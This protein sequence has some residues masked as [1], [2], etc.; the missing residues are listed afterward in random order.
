M[1]QLRPSPAAAHTGSTRTLTAVRIRRAL[2]AYQVGIWV[3]AV[4]VSCQVA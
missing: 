2:L 3:L 4:L 1:R